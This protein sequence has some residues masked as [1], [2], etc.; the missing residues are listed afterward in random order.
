MQD[1]QVM[2]AIQW[3]GREPR[4]CIY[5]YIYYILCSM[6]RQGATK[7]FPSSSL[8]IRSPF[9]FEVVFW[10]LL[11]NMNWL[12]VWN[13]FYVSIYWEFHHPNWRTPSFF[14]GVGIPPTRGISV[15][16]QWQL[17]V[18]D[19]LLA[20]PNTTVGNGGDYLAKLVLERV[21]HCG[22]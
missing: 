16:F 13:I 22:E 2:L 11:Q 8:L 4:R 21:H 20:L 19:G 3:L 17:P 18:V 1:I 15:V 12:V 5:I 9:P 10:T 14:R 6:G 7:S